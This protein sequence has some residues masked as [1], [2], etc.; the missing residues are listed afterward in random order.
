MYP[1]PAVSIVAD[2]GHTRETK[3]LG[4]SVKRANTARQKML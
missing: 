2:D 3:S 1:D 4:H